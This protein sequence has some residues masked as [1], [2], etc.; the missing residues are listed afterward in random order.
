MPAAPETRARPLI[1]YVR[2][3]RKGDRTDEKFHSPREQEER[4]RSYASSKGYATGEVIQDIDVSGGT[5]PLERPGMARA[6]EAIKAGGAGGLVAFSLDRLSR[7]PNHGEWLVR[8]ITGAGGI[9]TTPDMPEDITSPSGEFTFSMLL[10]VARLYRRTAGE[11]LQSAKA[12][13]VAQGILIG[14]TLP[15]GYRKRADRRMVLDPEMAPIVAELYQRRLAGDGYGVLA[16]FLK[17]RTGRPWNR[18]SIPYML[19][20]PLYHTGRMHHAGVVSDFEAG[21]I[22]DTATWHAAQRPKHV[23]DGRTVRGR[24]LLTGLLRCASCNR[25]LVPWRTSKANTR[26]GKPRYRC[27]AT[28]CEARASVRADLVEALVVDEAMRQS[29]V[30]AASADV[31][32]LAVLETALDDAARRFE[33]VQTPEAQDALGEAWAATA[34]ERREARDAAAAALG[35]ARAEAG[36]SVEGRT[37]SLGQVW[38]DLSP[39]GQREALAWHFDAI[40]VHKVGRGEDPR[41]SFTVR[42]TRP[43][44]PI[45]LKPIELEWQPPTSGPPPIDS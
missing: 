26:G 43:Y 40:H 4:A 27:D 18:K 16:N 25:R 15:L 29:M 7:D 39:E 2:V 22:V 41:L 32:D 37:L 36:V 42:A 45:E 31:P 20:N 35:A 33:Q 9:I 5:H 10:G 1:V 17:E 21:A 3:S 28:A 12:R 38:D 19:A 44:R 23:Q 11:R 14:N 30:L 6:L 34:K 24:W 8:E 13:A